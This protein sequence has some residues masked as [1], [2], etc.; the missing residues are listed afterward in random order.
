[1]IRSSIAFAAAIGLVFLVMA[2]NLTA[3]Q[4]GEK[5]GVPP[6]PKRVAEM[7]AVLKEKLAAGMPLYDV[8][9]RLGA[10]YALA[11]VKLLDDP[12]VDR[13]QLLAALANGGGDPAVVMP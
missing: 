10:D 13:G 2:L 7:V 8:L 11:V 3:A 5:L 9:S 1:M 6:D 12:K 4:G